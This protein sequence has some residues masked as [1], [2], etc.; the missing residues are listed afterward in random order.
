ML[1]VLGVHSNVAG[2]EVCTAGHAWLSMNFA[3]GRST[4]VGLWAEGGL[5]QNNHFIRDPVGFME[6][7]A[8]VFEVNFGKEDEGVIRQLLVD[9]GY[10]EC[11][12]APTA[13]AR[14]SAKVGGVSV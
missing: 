5:L 3:N 13:P 6:G 8:E 7:S 14:V 2:G 1:N 12:A 4:S 11:L 9:S 10:A